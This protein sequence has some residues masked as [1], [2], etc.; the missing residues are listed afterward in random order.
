M[1]RC[2]GKPM[3]NSNLENLCIDGNIKMEFQEER[4]GGMDGIDFALDRDRWLAHVKAVM[5]LW[6]P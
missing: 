2:M 4:L 6:V 1:M 5:N 3:G